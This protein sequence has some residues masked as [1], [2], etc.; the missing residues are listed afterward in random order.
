MVATALFAYLITIGLRPFLFEGSHLQ[1]LKYFDKKQGEPAHFYVFFILF[2]F[3]IFFSFFAYIFNLALMF[4]LLFVQQHRRIGCRQ[5]LDGFKLSLDGARFL[6]CR[7]YGI[8]GLLKFLLGFVQHLAKAA[9]LG[10]HR[11]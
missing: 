9:E 3:F 4:Q 10:L 11:T 8:A 6:G 2:I 5:F 1:Y 7:F